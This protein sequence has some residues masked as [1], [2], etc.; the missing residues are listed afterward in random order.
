MC[1]EYRRCSLCVCCMTKRVNSSKIPQVP[2]GS[3]GFER[4]LSD[5]KAHRSKDHIRDFPGGGAVVKNPPVG[6]PWWRSG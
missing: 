2:C 4:R 3:A 1:L 6:L 5:G